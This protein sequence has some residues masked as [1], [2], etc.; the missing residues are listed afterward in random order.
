MVAVKK[1]T[2]LIENLKQ[3]VINNA[4]N[5]SQMAHKNIIKILGYCLEDDTL[6]FVYEHAA[7]GSLYKILYGQQEFPL[8]VHVKIAVKTAE[9]LEYLHSSATCIITHGAIT[10]SNIL[11]DN[12]FMP[13]ITGEFKEAYKRENTGRAFFDKDITTEEDITILDEIGRLA[14]KSVGRLALKSV[15]IEGEAPTMKEAITRS[16]EAVAVGQCR[17]P[18][19]PACT[20][21]P[22]TRISLLRCFIQLAPTD[23]NAFASQAAASNSISAAAILPVKC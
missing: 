10:P 6:I 1:F 7:K 4:R 2:G 9:A 21:M 12:N 8:D 18:V 11:L 17:F 16:A 23:A 15:G 13:K 3:E 5:L 19:S 14:L 22:S 20:Q